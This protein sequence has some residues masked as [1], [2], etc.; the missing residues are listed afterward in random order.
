MGE[1]IITKVKYGGF[2]NFSGYK[3]IRSFKEIDHMLSH[4]KEIDD[5]WIF[6]ANTK[7]Y[8]I[9]DLENKTVVFNNKKYKL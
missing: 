2:D 9:D 6:I 4:P 8:T 1:I 7:K 3:V 5:D